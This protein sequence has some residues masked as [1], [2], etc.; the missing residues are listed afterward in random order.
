MS[1]F[2]QSKW[3]GGH[4][5]AKRREPEAKSCR[6]ADRNPLWKALAISEKVSAYALTPAPEGVSQ[7]PNLAEPEIKIPQMNTLAISHKVSA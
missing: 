3:L 5:G 1:Q 2:L 7:E 6:T 4:S